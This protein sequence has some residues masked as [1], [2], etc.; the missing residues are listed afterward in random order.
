MCEIFRFPIAD[1]SAK[2][3]GRG[4]GIRE[5]TPRQYQLVG[6]EDLREEL[7]KELGWASTSRT[8]KRTLKPTTTSGALKETCFIYRHHVEPRV[9]LYVPKEESF[10]TPLKYIDVTR[11]THTKQD[12][13]QEKRKDDCWNV[14]AKKSF[15]ES[16]KYSRSSHCWKNNLQ[17]DTRRPGEIDKHFSNYQSWERV[18]W[19]MDQDWKSLPEERTAKMGNR[20]TKTRQRSKVKEHLPDWSRWWRM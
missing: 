12:V 19:S 17:E 7:R 6:S 13:L 16:G 1:G 15:L 10:P 2:L 18:A 9:R 4:H 8:K 20:E 14:D 3:L 11:T 5:S